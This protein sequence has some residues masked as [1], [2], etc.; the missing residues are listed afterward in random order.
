M[1]P[2][3][4]LDEIKKALE[5]S[6][7][8]LIFFDD[9]CDGLTSFLQLRELN[10]DSIGILVR[11]NP[12]LDTSYLKYIE[13]HQPDKVFVLDK[14]M[15]EQE[16]IDK[17]SQKIYWLDH[18]PLQKNV[19]LNYYNPLQ[20]DPKNST[21]TSYW[22]YEI[23]KKHPWL[24]AIGIVSDWHFNIPE[25]FKKNYADL[26]PKNINTAEEALFNSKLGL[27]IKIISFNLKGSRKEIQKSLEALKKLKDPYEL[28][29]KNTEASTQLIKKFKSINQKFL[30]YKSCIDNTNKDFILF[31]YND[32]KVSISA[33]LS[34]ELVHENPKKV[35]LVGKEHSNKVMFSIRAKH[36]N[37]PEILDKIFSEIRGYGGGHENACGACIHSE[38]LDIFMTKIKDNLK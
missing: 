35:V 36:Q 24:A 16:F 29:K 2:Q 37:L 31:I 12:T 4:K 1:I 11:G 32:S 13:E 28:L 19:G 10:K 8:P 38:D 34:N 23:T 26:L 30:D 14:P 25:E 7:R 9:D 27:I 21:P 17:T 22:C 3:E 18:H 20:Y 15:I 5:T 6:S 33:D